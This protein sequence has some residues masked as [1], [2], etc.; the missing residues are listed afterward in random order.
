MIKLNLT[1]EKVLN[2]EFK[3]VPHGYDPLMVDRFFDKMLEDYRI[4]EENILLS[5]QEYIDLLK[6]IENLTKQSKDLEIQN[7]RLN[8]RLSNIKPTD[9]VTSDNVDLIKKVN[10]YERYIYFL[11]HDPKEAL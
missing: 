10:A 8:S 1:S 4:V 2:E 6:K 3:P 9:L 7:S 5:K 11:G